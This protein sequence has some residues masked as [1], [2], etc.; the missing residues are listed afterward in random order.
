MDRDDVVDTC[1]WDTFGAR[2]ASALVVTVGRQGEIESGQR[3]ENESDLRTRLPA[4]DRYQP[5]TADAGFLGQC[6]LAQAELAA[7]IPYN[8]TEVQGRSYL[9]GITSCRRTKTL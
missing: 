4:F 3:L 5:L 6:A 9:H 2:A 1:G 8:Q 7:S